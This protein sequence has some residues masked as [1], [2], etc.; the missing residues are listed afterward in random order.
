MGGKT[1]IK[2]KKIITKFR[3]MVTSRE[4]GNGWDRK[5]T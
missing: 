5:K 1:I 4:K 3:V 2:R